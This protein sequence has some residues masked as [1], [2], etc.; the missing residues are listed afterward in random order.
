MSYMDRTIAT[1]QQY[2]QATAATTWVFNH[3][4]GYMPIVDVYVDV[5]GALHKIIPASVEASSLSVTVTFS[6]A[7]SGVMSL[8]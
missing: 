8:G 2:A 3:Q 5:D 4:L 1:R 7:Y 6:Q